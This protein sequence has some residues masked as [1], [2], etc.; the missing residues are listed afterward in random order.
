MINGRWL[1]RPRLAGE[2]PGIMRPLFRNPCI[3]LLRFSQNMN[4][5]DFCEKIE[6]LTFYPWNCDTTPPKDQDDEPSL[7][8]RRI[9]HARLDKILD[10]D[11]PHAT[12]AIMHLLTYFEWSWLE[13]S[14]GPETAKGTDDQTS[15]KL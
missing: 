13:K 11:D 2:P 5:D 3:I 12:N 1:T 4:D 10:A 7:S 9:W 6:G 15:P 8:D 14:A